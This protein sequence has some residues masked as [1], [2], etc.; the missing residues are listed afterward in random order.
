MQHVAFKH[1]A[2]SLKHM[3]ILGPTSTSYKLQYRI[4]FDKQRTTITQQL[5]TV[6]PF[7]QN[8]VFKVQHYSA[9]Q[10]ALDKI[11]DNFRRFVGHR[12]QHQALTLTYYIWIFKQY[13]RQGTKDETIEESMD[14]NCEELYHITGHRTGVSCKPNGVDMLTYC[15]EWHAAFGC[16]V[17][18]LGISL[19]FG[20]RYGCWLFIGFAAAP[21]PVLCS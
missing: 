18:G 21:C 1:S 5:S 11:D 7:V 3:Q 2:W 12:L 20:V 10:W 6:Y 13:T 8:L 15:N 9:A 14:E 17:S 19:M 16:Q 4:Q